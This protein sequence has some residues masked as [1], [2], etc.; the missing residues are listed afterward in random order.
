M[1]IIPRIPRKAKVTTDR[2]LL[3]NRLTTRLAADIGADS[4]LKLLDI[5]TG[6]GL[7]AL[8]RAGRTELT[9]GGLEEARELIDGIEEAI[10]TGRRVELIR[11][12]WLI[13]VDAQGLGEGAEVLVD[14]ITVYR[15]SAILSEVL[16]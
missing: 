2:P 11:Y 13:E 4:T 3:L 15:R 16:I 14:D 1:S 12:G 8:K 5:L 7:D 9:A 10:Q 6:L